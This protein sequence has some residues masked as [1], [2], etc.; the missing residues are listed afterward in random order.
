VCIVEEIL[1]TGDYSPTSHAEQVMIE[2]EA[3]DKACTEGNTDKTRPGMKEE[4]V[5]AEMT[6]I[7]AKAGMNVE[8]GNKI[9]DDAGNYELHGPFLR[10]E[11]LALVFELR[12]HMA[13]QEHRALLMGQRL[14]LLLDTYS[15]APTKRKCPFCAQQFA[16]PARSTWQ[17]RKG[18]R[19][20]GI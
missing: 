8:V 19:S 5:G 10:A 16:I 7:E 3:R 9:F 15:N 14:D 6:E 2:D 1:W 11:H 17:T 4:A 18:D 20:S 13:D 12:G